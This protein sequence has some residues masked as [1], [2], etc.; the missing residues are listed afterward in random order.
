M[1]KV[2]PKQKQVICFLALVLFFFLLLPGSQG[3][4]PV[5]I[6]INSVDENYLIYEYECI[7]KQTHLTF[8]TIINLYLFLKGS[9]MVFSRSK[10]ELQG[11]Q[12]IL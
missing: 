4:V 3:P 11:L 2:E 1:M 7:N 12:T 5:K 9:T 8:L 10:S 6:K